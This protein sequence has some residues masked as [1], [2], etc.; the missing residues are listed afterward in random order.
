MEEALWEDM[1][2]LPTHHRVDE[3]FLYDWVDWPEFGSTAGTGYA[4]ATFSMAFFGIFSYIIYAV[5][6]S[7]RVEDT[8]FVA[9]KET[10]SG[11]RAS[12]VYSGVGTFF[13]L[14]ALYIEFTGYMLSATW[15][16]FGLILLVSGLFAREK[17][18][19]L[20]AL[21][22]LVVT[23]VKV[24]LVDMQGEEIITRVI[25]LG[26]LGIVLVIAAFGYSKYLETE[27]GSTPGSPS[28]SATSTS[29][30]ASEETT[31]LSVTNAVQSIGETV[32]GAGSAVSAGSSSDTPV[33][34]GEK[35]M[36]AGKGVNEDGSSEEDEGMSLLTGNEDDEQAGGKKEP[37]E[38][39]GDESSE[40]EKSHGK[41][42]GE[43]DESPLTKI[44]QNKDTGEK[45]EAGDVGSPDEDSEG[46]VGGKVDEDAETVSDAEEDTVTGESAMDSVSPTDAEAT[47]SDE[48]VNNE[49]G[50]TDETVGTGEGE[51]EKN[52]GKSD[53]K[54]E[55]E[56]SKE[57]PGVSFCPECGLE[58]DEGDNFC[59]NC[60]FDLREKE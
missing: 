51:S 55:G 48:E 36:D 21:G 5:I 15:A 10:E 12:A 16:V 9:G 40:N 26:V 47:D 60:G 3:R 59:I 30:S 41:S 17:R 52:E 42:Q 35:E 6:K 2:L 19:R 27:F 1:V 34:S 13:I 44:K 53:T 22:I 33:A 39:R 45:E 43:G 18:L 28:P 14:T 58:V 31:E 4:A 24:F 37:D 11:V 20:Q 23:I 25:S 38:D 8:R 49:G 7:N 54:D 57:K 32:S 56:P 29:G 46:V 50:G